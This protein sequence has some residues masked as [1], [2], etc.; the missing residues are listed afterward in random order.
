MLF[1]QEPHGGTGEPAVR[2][3]HTQR[4]FPLAFHAPLSTPPILLEKE[5]LHRDASIKM[6]NKPWPERSAPRSSQTIQDGS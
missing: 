4:F 3:P 6:P 5:Q 2:Q 1:P